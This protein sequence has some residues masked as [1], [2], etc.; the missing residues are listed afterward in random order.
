MTD[1]PDSELLAQFARNDSEAAFAELVRRYLALV[2]SVAL[3]HTSDPGHAQD[4]TQAV[5]I[6]LARKAAALGGRPVLAGW[7]YQ[8]ARL[9]AANYQRA[10]M[11]R[12]RREQEAF[13]QSTLEETGPDAVWRELSPQL[14]AAMAVLNASERDALVLRY[15]QNKSMAEVGKFLG[16]EENTAQKRIGRALEKLRKFFGKR[17]IALSAA[18]IAGAVSA[19]SVQAAP[20]ALAN[21]VIALALTK[22]ATAGASTLTLI[23]GALKL[24]AWTKTK[25]TIVTGVTILLTA[26]VTDVAVNVISAARTRAALAA[27]QGNWEG[28]IKANQVQLRLV[29][30][31]FKTNDT[32]RA[33]L[34]SVDQGVT[35]VPVTKLSAGGSSINVGLPAIGATYEASLSPDRTVLS[36]TWKQ[37]KQTYP[38]V[39][40][41]TSEAD[42]VAEPM[43]ADDFAPRTDS[44]LQGAWEGALKAGGVEL[45]LNLRIAE[46][47]TGTFH[48]QVDSV[49]QGARNLSVT[50]MTYNKPAVHFEMS[51]I[52]CSFDG[53]VNDRDDQISGTWTQLGKSLP[54]TFRR[55][56]P[57]SQAAADAADYGQGL[58]NQV[59]GHWKGALEVN[60][61]VLRIV[62]HVAL[63][64]DGSYSASMDSPDQGA[65][66]IPATKAKFIY[67]DVQLE[68]KGMAAVYLGKLENGRLSGT[69][70]QG[71]VSLPLKLERGA[72]Q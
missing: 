21:P 70:R 13:M 19:N 58:P 31:I 56:S 14:D 55:A 15:F 66:G 25:I 41:R 65:F 67:P 4:I 63:M 57:D 20:A 44:D 47:A 34:D 59:Q 61:L 36:G 33:V 11:R 8:T 45:R 54:I 46:P 37:L 69:W 3:R 17:G 10:E 12:I 30:R 9:T 48:A 39:L 51:A 2:H 27:M 62:F 64:P 6:I 43:A 1:A 18:A 68:W 42:R 60:K 32:Y 71:T 50:T 28:V 22:G 40:K 38:L 26:G 24:M 49:D 35:G 5:F 29:I 72:A 52:N 53:V 23:K 7:L 16:L